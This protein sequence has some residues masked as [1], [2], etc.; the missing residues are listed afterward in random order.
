MRRMDS[1][2]RAK[3]GTLA[4]EVV[5]GHELLGVCA[6]GGMG[7]VYLA[8]HL[9]LGMNRAVKVLRTNLR[10]DE[11]SRERF[12]REAQILA[13]LQHNSI[14]GIIEFG[15]LQNGWPFLVLEYIDGPSLD[16]L[17][18]HGP[19]S[20]HDV[21]IVIEQVAVALHYAHSLGVI[22]RDLKP[23]NVLVR[24]GDLRQVKIIDF[25]LARMIDAKR[26]TAD[27]QMI[28]S[29]HYMAPEQ[30]ESVRDATAAVDVYAMAGIAYT[31]LSGEPPVSGT[32]LATMAAQVN[33]VPQRLSE[34]CA[35]LPELLDTLLFACLAKDPAQ[36][37]TSDELAAHFSRLARG[38]EVAA[39]VGSSSAER[40]E[41]VASPWG[42]KAGYRNIA[43]RVLDTPPPTPAGATIASQI[44]TLI[45][46]IA[47]HL[48]TSDPELTSLLRL[49]AGV[50]RQRD[51]V[52][53]E[54][55]GCSD[56]AQR[57]AL[58][59]R[60]RTLEAQQQPLQRRMIEVVEAHRRYATG[61]IKWLFEQI[62]RAL[63]E[64][65]DLNR[66]AG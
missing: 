8:R 14:V 41:L 64:L 24:S 58:A 55:A 29:P 9:R 25:G 15:E 35:A 32:T 12:S 62:D 49:E 7:E 30:V 22:H 54:L 13:R 42:G 16:Q 36:R 17:L 59:E 52:E 28:G 31:L 10:G 19:L 60:A 61:T 21:M 56:D 57:E 53:H 37:P 51:E 63:D 23:S 43:A 27:G 44:I 65:D 48:S 39:R 3:R 47:A 11:K 6:A 40:I 46:E 26:L 20:L 2:P 1:S 45:A 34:R 50:R 66:T 4:G 38:I 18:E 33:E 5:A